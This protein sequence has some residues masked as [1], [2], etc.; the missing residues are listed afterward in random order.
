MTFLDHVPFRID[1]ASRVCTVQYSS[2]RVVKR[3]SEVLICHSECSALH[4]L[5][6]L[7]SPGCRRRSRIWASRFFISCKC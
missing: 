6:R 7:S 2:R 5:P 4:T 3:H 1:A